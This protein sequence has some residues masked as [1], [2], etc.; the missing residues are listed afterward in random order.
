MP[1]DP[2]VQV[3]IVGVL[4]TLIT[5]LGVIVVAIMNNKKE[6]GSAADAGVEATLRERLTLRDEQI[7]DLRADVA[8]LERRLGHAQAENQ[9]KTDLIEHLTAELAEAKE[10]QRDG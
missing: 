8:D 3:A 1:K 6:R 7:L 4:T 9:E 5:T 10:K 2:T